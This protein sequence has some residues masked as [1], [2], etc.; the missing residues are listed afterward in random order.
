MIGT[1]TRIPFPKTRELTIDIV[2]LARRKNQVKGCI[3]LDVTR[4]RDCIRQ[5][6]ADTGQGISFTGWIA[7]CIAQAVSEHKQVHALRYGKRSMILFDDVD[8]LIMVNKTIAGEEMALPYIVRK[9]N[10]KT[11]QQINNEIRSAQS[12]SAQQDDMLLGDKPGF[13]RL[14]PYMPKF[15]RRAIGRK[16]MRDP[17][18]IK[19]N[20]GTVEITAVGMVGNFAGWAFPI[21]PQPLCFALGGITRK[22]GVIDDKIL[23]REYLN[24]A[25]TFDHDVI[26]GAPFSRFISYL[27][28][29]V[30]KGFGLPGQ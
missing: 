10:E 24:M 26:D 9:A 22:P 19:R 23:I 25:F 4:G 11:V 12:Q 6:K 15:I 30:G 27:A 3:E 13:A 28:E 2:E 29:L 16:I 8:V 17:F 14:F 5:I 18:M 7:K 20:V 21:S 1:Y